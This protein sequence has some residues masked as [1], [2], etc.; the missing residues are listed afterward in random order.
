MPI[1]LHGDRLPGRPMPGT[2]HLTC[3]GTC[4]A[5]TPHAS[6]TG[7]HGEE[8]GECCLFCGTLQLPNKS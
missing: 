8:I 2:F 1:I 4:A 3:A 7:P 5:I 6:L